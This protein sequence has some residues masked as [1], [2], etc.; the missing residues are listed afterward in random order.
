MAAIIRETYQM[1][2]PA[3]QTGDRAPAG[4]LIMCLGVVCLCANDAIAKALGETY[5]PVQI[6]FIRNLIALPIAAA[7]ALVMGGP[8][9]LVSRS[10]L[11]HLG[12]GLIWMAAAYLFFTGLT[13]LELAEATTLIFAAPAIIC[14]LSALVL[15]EQVGWRRWSAVLVGFGGVLIVVQPGTDAF[16]T[17]A[18]YPLA[19]AFLY[20]LMMISSRWL[21]ARESVWTLTLYL[22]GSGALISAVLV[23]FFWVPIRAEDL[24]LFAGIA[25]AGTVGATMITQA[26]RIAPAAVV[27]PFDYTSLI[28]AV[29]LGYFLWGEVPDHATYLGASVIVAS[30]LYIVY[31][32]W[33]H[34]RSTKAVSRLQG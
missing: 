22:V 14:A 32:E 13:L 26:F 11:V 28:W 18:L 21:D 16:Q 31:R 9:A 33:L 1:A 23:P 20:A 7:I 25:A 10:P 2:L 30:G 8:Q 17:A 29:L 3:H 12:R 6:L 5:P 24:W 4:I 27:A 15:K 19:T 34:S